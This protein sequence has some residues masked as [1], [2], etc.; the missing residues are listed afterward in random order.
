M[1]GLGSSDSVVSESLSF[2]VLSA[3]QKSEE[4]IREILRRKEAQLKLKQERK[5]K[6]EQNIL[7]K[8]EKREENKYVCGL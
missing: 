4:D 5:K 6:Q 7:H 1:S 8:K 3:V 2:S